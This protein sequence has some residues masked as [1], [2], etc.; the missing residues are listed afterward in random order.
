MLAG[1]I[2]DVTPVLA[3]GDMVTYRVR[4][5]VPC[6]ATL[7]TNMAKAVGPDGIPSFA[8]SSVWVG[9]SCA[10]LE[11]QNVAPAVVTAGTKARY[12]M[13][14]IN[15]GP[16][17]ADRVQLSATLPA[18][19]SPG[20]S[21]SLLG[22][23]PPPPSPPSPPVRF[24][25]DVP[26]SYAAGLTTSTDVVSSA[27]CDLNLGNNVASSPT[28]VDVQADYSITKE[29]VL[30]QP[31]VSPLELSVAYTLKATY[32][33]GPSCPCVTITDVFPAHLVSPHWCR[34]A[35]C[36]PMN[37][38]NLADTLCLQQQGE[39]ETFQAS[40]L[41]DG[42]FSGELCNTASLSLP[43]PGFDPDLGNN[44][45]MACVAVSPPS[46]S[47]SLPPVPTLSPAAL[48]LFALLLPALAVA[49]LRRRAVRR[50]E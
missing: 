48:A 49:R 31:P 16:C 7:I 47:P 17:A 12:E 13:I 24:T 44:T 20:N 23:L 43:P 22:H 9:P 10:D 14:V 26:C 27:T 6:G 4:G 5:V 34:G 18:G 15:H 45:A 36:P 41:V 11:V 38:G 50:R 21:L 37:P 8:S 3:A 29:A 39:T 33:R 46:P 40:A 35:G 42:T 19:F 30:Q 28:L 25:E 32:L 2:D 1:Q